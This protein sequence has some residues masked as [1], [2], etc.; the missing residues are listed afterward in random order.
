MA[1]Y[2]LQVT[3]DL[4][5]AESIFEQYSAY[6]VESLAAVGHHAII[7]DLF[8]DGENVNAWVVEVAE[9]KGD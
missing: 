8:V 5:T 3:T 4:P 2:T 9:T 7:A 1:E 6:L